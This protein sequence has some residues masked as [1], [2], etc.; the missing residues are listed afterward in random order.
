MTRKLQE[1][2]MFPEVER[3]EI[4]PATMATFQHESPFVGLAFN[5][6]AEAA[7]YVCVAACIMGERPTWDRDRA[8]IGGNMV[9]LYKLASGLLDQTM[10]DRAE[11]GVIFAR[12]IFET[13]VNVRYLVANFSRELLDSYVRHSLRHDRKLLNEIQ[14][15]IASRGGTLLPIEDRMLRS[16][17]RAER[18]A[19]IALNSVDL[20]DRAP[21]GGK[22]LH[23]KAKAVGLEYIYLAAFAGLS[24]DVHG[25]WH[26]IYQY[27][28]ETDDAED[29][30]SEFRPSLKWT[31]PRP[32]HLFSLSTIL[33]S[34]TI[35]A[36]GFLGGEAALSQL[37]PKLR[38]LQQR[39]AAAD[40]AHELYLSS[41]KWPEI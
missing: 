39:V 26:N 37:E 18:L 36:V 28:L 16:L 34:T 1:W 40:E 9:R 10:Q 20:K 7:Q 6:L 2:C 33:V 19:G 38:D 8:V 5:L 31:I 41:K 27:Q 32:Q 13:C 29:A 15:N 4:D 23:D 12:L 22:H 21:W 35:V 3:A 14:E 11:T 24:H 25:S 30:P 17:A